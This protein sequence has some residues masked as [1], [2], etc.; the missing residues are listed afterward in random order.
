MSILTKQ[1]C[2]AAVRS[3]H[4][5]WGNQHSVVLTHR[6]SQVG[7]CAIHRGI[8][9]ASTRGAVAGALAPGG[10]GDTLG[11]HH[12]DHSTAPWRVTVLVNGVNHTSWEES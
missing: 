2:I 11:L 1:E 4:S 8:G 10:G 5:L 12:T 3:V 9:S 6:A 7:T